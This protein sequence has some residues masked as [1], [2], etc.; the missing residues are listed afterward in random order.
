MRV[1][2][3]C[4]SWP[5]SFSR[6]VVA[7]LVIHTSVALLAQSGLNPVRV[8]WEKL[9]YEDVKAVIRETTDELAKNLNPLALRMRSSAY[10]RNFE[11]EKGKA[12]A[13]A[14]LV[15]LKSPATAEEFEAK[16]Y[17][18]RRAEKYSEAI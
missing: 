17:S 3:K 1:L 2:F 9:M 8:R 11:P 10:Y 14:A 4:G 7:F 6:L 13:A 12:D 15:L 18:E 16:C 5:R